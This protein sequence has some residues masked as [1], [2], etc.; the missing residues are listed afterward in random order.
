MLAIKLL[1]T[2]EHNMALIQPFCKF[3]LLR[4]FIFFK[5]SASSSL[6]SSAALTQPLGGCKYLKI[7]DEYLIDNPAT[8]PFQ[9][10]ESLARLGILAFLPF[11]PSTE[12]QCPCF[13]NTLCNINLRPETCYA[14]VGW[15]WFN[16]N[17]TLAT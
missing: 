8:F 9:C 10:N 12:V 4:P 7:K 1:K 17:S 15:I 14:R 13:R 3:T 2:S 11:T 5:Q 6:D 16:L